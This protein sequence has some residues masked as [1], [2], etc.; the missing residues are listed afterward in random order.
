MPLIE[1]IVDFWRRLISIFSTFRFVDLLDI[2]LVALVLF[3]LIKLIRDTRAFQLAKGFALL[4]IAY[5]LILTLKMQ[6]SAFIFQKL[7]SDFII[8]IIILFQPE[9]RHA[10]ES[11]GGSKLSRINPFGSR[12][13]DSEARD[14]VKSAINEVSKACSDLS[15]KRTGAII[16]FENKTLL[17]DVVATGTPIDATTTRELIGNIFFP[18]SPLHDGA[19]IIREGRISA[20]G[21]ILP[22]TQNSE[23][24]R[25]LGTR[26]RAAI[27][28]SENSDAVIVV[29][30]EETGH[31]S[32]AH[33]GILERNLS[34]AIARERILQ[35][36]VYANEP[37]DTNGGFI[38]RFFG[39]QKK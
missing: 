28:I 21:C 36:L 34:E 26:H 23:L 24:S 8:L 5:L 14:I 16:V 15:K 22:L 31:I 30:S 3:S 1:N 33:K 18:L 29:V 11:V 12:G 4:G 13:G 2:L 9:I 7:I 20:A 27:G 17:G 38:K 32:V 37:T 35:A 19:V 6:A 25:D 39:G 10:L